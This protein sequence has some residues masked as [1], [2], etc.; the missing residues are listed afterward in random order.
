MDNLEF[1][2]VSLLFN[3]FQS[4]LNP[5]RYSLQQRVILGSTSPTSTRYDVPKVW[6]FMGEFVGEVEE[7]DVDEDGVGWGPLLKVR[8]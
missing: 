4:E 6:G 7:V 1:Q 2:Q 8:V 5:S 3:L